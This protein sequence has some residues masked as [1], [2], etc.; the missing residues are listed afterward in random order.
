MRAGAAPI[1]GLS[2][3]PRDNRRPTSGGR[4]IS[5]DRLR[6]DWC[7]A[8]DGLA[9]LNVDE[10]ETAVQRCIA[11][12]ALEKISNGRP[13]GVEN[14]SSFVR[15]RLPGDWFNHLLPEANSRFLAAAGGVM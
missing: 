15:Q 3:R 1:R 6:F 7:P 10:S 5:P 13:A 8:G 14:R 12:G 9:F 4:R 2:T 11:G